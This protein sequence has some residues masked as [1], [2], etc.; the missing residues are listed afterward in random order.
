MTGI[1]KMILNNN[2]SSQVLDGLIREELYSI[3]WFLRGYCS[4]LMDKKIYDVIDW[5]VK[6]LK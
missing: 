2:L 5:F 1:K 4:D 6:W 3:I